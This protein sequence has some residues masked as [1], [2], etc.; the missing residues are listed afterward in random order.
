M[1]SGVMMGRMPCSEPRTPPGGK[2]NSLG[3]LGPVISAS[4]TP[5]FL[6]AF[7]SA[8]ASRAVT[9]DLPTPPLPLRTAIVC[10]I[11]LNGFSLGREGWAVPSTA[12]RS[13]SVIAP[14]VT[15][16]W[17][18]PGRASTAAWALARI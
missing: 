16:T 3:M 12:R 2:P 7:A 11:L 17:L 9:E 1:P 4:S 10:P 18:T 8:T 5:T 15:V 6:P 13:S 14:S